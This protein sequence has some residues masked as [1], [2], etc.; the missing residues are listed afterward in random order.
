MLALTVEGFNN[1][2]IDSDC[3]IHKEKFHF[4]VKST[5]DGVHTVT[6]YR[7]FKKACAD[8]KAK[9]EEIKKRSK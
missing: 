7:S 1:V 4:V 9:A 6:N 2:S 5:I 3:D 8:Y